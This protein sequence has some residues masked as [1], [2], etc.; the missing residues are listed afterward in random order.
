MFYVACDCITL[1]ILLLRLFQ[2]GHWELFQLNLVSLWLSSSL[3]PFF[4]FFEHFLSG[5]R[6]CSRFILDIFCLSPRIHHFSKE[7]WCLLFE[8]DIRNQDLSVL[9][10]CF[11]FERSFWGYN[12]LEWQ[13]F[14]FQPIA[15]WPSLF[16]MRNQLLILL[17][18]SCM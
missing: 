6:R 13:V 3:W 17:G 14:F 10:A 18:F 2:V 12:I 7:A 15:F 9:I 11:H 8:N 4:F 16:Q 5:T 1:F